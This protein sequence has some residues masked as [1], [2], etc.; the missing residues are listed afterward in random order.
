[1]AKIKYKEQMPPR[2][3]I[4]TFRVSKELGKA[5]DEYVKHTGFESPGQFLR[6]VSAQAIGRPELGEAAELTQRAAEIRQRLVHKERH[7][8]HN[9]TSKE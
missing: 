9:K 6:E 8:G 4:I 7:H 1:M 2:E 3:R 5:L